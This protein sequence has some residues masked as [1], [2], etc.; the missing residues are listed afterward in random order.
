V[1]AGARIGHLAGLGDTRDPAVLIPG[2]PHALRADARVVDGVAEALMRVADVVGGVDVGGWT[3]EAAIAFTEAA[4]TL[5]TR[6][7]V[8]ASALA[9]AA[10]A[11][12]AH[13]GAVEWAQGAA[14]RAIR[15]HDLSGACAAPDL[16]GVSTLTAG[17]RTAVAVLD[18]A[19]TQVDVSGAA[20]VAALEQACR[21]APSAPGFWNQVAYHSSELW[22]GVG[23]SVTDLATFVR[24]HSQSR[25]L[26]DPTGW[27][28]SSYE[29][30][31][32]FA[33][34]QANHGEQFRRDLIDA[35]TWT[36]SPARAIGH[37]FPDAAIAAASGGSGLLATRSATA[38]V[39]IAAGS[40]R[41][42]EDAVAAATVAETG[43]QVVAAPEATLLL[44]TAREAEGLIRAAKPVGPALKS[45]AWHRSASFTVDEIAQRGTVFRTMGG[46]GVARML[47]QVPG[48]VEGAAGRFEWLVDGDKLVHQMF[49]RGGTVNGIPIAP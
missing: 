6:V 48:E 24:D 10:S 19:R 31:E 4:A 39:R 25:M 11:L 13:A 29:L 15:L 23:E 22:R 41:F 27:A 8:A 16:F 9:G 7:L 36:T 45:D 12:S 44:P 26:A 46:D 21:D 32:G 14:R 20:A 33:L 5:R 42:G 37:L 18:D 35:D 34:S 43:A 38:G 30:V 1:S 40:V 47:V 3:G 17:Q 49:V 28:M 2:D